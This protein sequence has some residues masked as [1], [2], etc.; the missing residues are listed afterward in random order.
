MPSAMLVA[1]TALKTVREPPTLI[2]R[3]GSLG[4]TPPASKQ[5]T[6][7][8]AGVFW[9]SM[10]AAHGTPVPTATVRPS[11]RTRAAQAI[12]SSVGVKDMPLSRLL[13]HVSPAREPHVPASQEQ[14]H[15]VYRHRGRV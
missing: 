5:M 14:F 13:H 4:A 10:A 8:G 9:A 3:V 7:L 11:S 12:I 1:M 6:R 15:S 2:G